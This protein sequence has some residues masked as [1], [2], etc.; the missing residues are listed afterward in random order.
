MIHR[1]RQTEGTKARLSRFNRREGQR[2][3]GGHPGGGQRSW[4]MWSQV[5]EEKDEH[6]EQRSTDLQQRNTEFRLPAGLWRRITHSDRNTLNT[7]WTNPLGFNS[8][9]RLPLQLLCGKSKWL[10]GRFSSTWG[11]SDRAGHEHDSIHL[12]NC[13]YDEMINVWTKSAENCSWFRHDIK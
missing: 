1:V 6:L 5:F 7:L 3:E 11:V 9:L 12:Q 4:P 13:L 10:I 8:A 2:W